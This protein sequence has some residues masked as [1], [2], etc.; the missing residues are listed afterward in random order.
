MINIAHSVS[1]VQG[2]FIRS[3]VLEN[4]LMGPR[5]EGKTEAGLVAIHNHA[6]HQA[7][8]YCPMPWAVI[9][10]T[11]ANLERTTLQSIVRPRPESFAAKILPYLQIKDGGHHIE[12]PGLWELW[13]F[14]ADSPADLNKLQSMQLAGLWLEETAPAAETDIG[15]GIAEDVWTI[16]ITSLRHP[17]TTN[18]RAQITQNYSDED[19]WTWQRFFVEDDPDR[20]LFR[21][22]RGANVHVD[23]QYRTNMYKALKDRPN[24][25]ARL[26]EG[27]P[28]HVY[29]GEAVTP[30]Y[31]DRHRASIILD[32]LPGVICYRLWDGGLNPSCILCQITPGGRLFVLDALREPNGGMKQFITSQVKPVIAAHYAKITQWRD[33]GDPALNERDQSDSTVT[34]A[35]IINEELKA[36]FEPGVSSWEARRE[37]VKELLNRQIDGEPLVLVSKRA[38]ILHQALSG[39]WHYKKT[40]TGAVLRDKPVKDMHSHPADAFCH[41][42]AKIFQYQPAMPV[43]RQDYKKRACSYGTKT[44]GGNRYVKGQK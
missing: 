18:R 43:R 19:H 33:L 13:L 17:V 9:R 40:P 16:G 2:A 1:R 35:S 37:S 29:S 34:A 10:D 12:L 38:L 27:K 42:I 41:G 30:E 7:P 15:S 39:G 20:A 6:V 24:L 26:V 14:G 28:A 3:T 36:T 25:L 4:C 8:E 11:W 22:P 5:G 23:D 32:P 31:S 21:I 44:L